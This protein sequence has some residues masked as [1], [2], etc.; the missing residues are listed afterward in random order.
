MGVCGTEAGSQR[1]QS[2]KHQVLSPTAVTDAVLRMD[3]CH[4]LGHKHTSQKGAQTHSKGIGVQLTQSDQLYAAAL[5][6]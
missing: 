4:A 6:G 5:R 3:A 1:G 2:V